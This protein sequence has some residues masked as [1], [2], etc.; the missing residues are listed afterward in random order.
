M[1][2]ISR[3]MARRIAV[4]SQLLD[5]RAKLNKGKEGVAQTAERLGYVQIDT[6]AVVERA[7]HHTLW[8]R[9]PDYT[10]A[11]LHE[12]LAIDRRVFE[13]WGRQASYLPMTDYRFYLP[14]M[15]RPA[16]ERDKWERYILQQHGHLMSSVLE[17]IRKDGPLTSADFKPPPGT[18]RGT[19][20]DWKPAKMVLE[21]LFWRGELMITE[22]QNFQRVYDLTERVLPSGVDTRL[23]GN[24]ELGRFLVRRALS[25]Y[26]LARDIEIVDHLHAAAR[27]VI[28][29]AL[30]ELVAAGEIT[31]VTLERDR[32]DQYC[33]L[34]E[35]IDQLGRL[36]K[37]A[38]R[39]HI[40]S[41][42][43]NL[44]IQRDRIRRL[45]DFDFTI[46]C[47]VPAAKRK[48]GYFS[49]PILWD[50]Q[51]VGR[52]DA[53]AERKD[54]RFLVRKIWLEESFRNDERFTE[55][56]A[57]KLSALARFNLCKSV[58][59]DRTSPARWRAEITRS[60]KRA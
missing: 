6:I 27:N 1:L 29:D 54:G 38:P 10:P 46:E 11:I 34:T 48:F 12:L 3:S 56:L 35:K 15:R 44:I 58:E 60:L 57:K 59:I 41:P 20:W 43:D 14:R 42:F 40:L 52:L 2:K 16:R 18:R 7:H 39:L 22:R 55:S 25:A 21:L 8:T 36:R 19:W 53:K 32:D 5:G 4:H 33:V 28:I 37:T 31:R 23:P 45:F 13:Y 17:R 51:L 30:E 9:C 24:D 47:Y 26:G 49:L 50:E